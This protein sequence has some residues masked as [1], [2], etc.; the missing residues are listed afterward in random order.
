MSTNSPDPRQHYQN[1]YFVQ[2]HSNQ[3]ERTRLAVQ[4]QMLTTG[5]GGVLPEQPDPASFQRVLDVGCGTGGWLIEVAKTYPAIT[6]LFGID[7]NNYPLEYART[8]AEAELVHNR[9][10]FRTMDALLILEFPQRYF[11]LVNMRFATPFMRTWDWA[12]LLTEMLRVTRPGG[13]IRLTEYERITSSSPALVRLLE[14]AGD[15]FYR[16]GHLF[17]KGT[18]GDTFS[19]GTVG[20][21]KDLERLLRQYKIQNIQTHR[22]SQE[23]PFGTPGSESFAEDLRLG[24]RTIVPFLRKWGCLTDDYET[25]YQAMLAAMQQQDY[26]ASWSLLTAWGTK[27]L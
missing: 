5:M 25:L 12:K 19:E 21:A 17:S 22:S 4:D 8:Q 26:V 16:A 11:D 23:P 20:V 24:L 3:D 27:A 7:A 1:T 2:D 15:A 9:V 13:I 14:M 18:T 10:E 6:Q